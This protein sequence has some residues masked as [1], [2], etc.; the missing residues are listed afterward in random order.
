MKNRIIIFSWFLLFGI[1]KAQALPAK[2]LQAEERQNVCPHLIYKKSALSVALLDVEKGEVICIC[3]SDLK[4]LMNT[5]K[6]KL[7]QINQ[8]VTLQ[9]LAEKYE[10]NEQDILTLIKN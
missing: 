1:S 2:C 9:R 5:E 8:S 10:L 7:N 3:L 4:T 6:S